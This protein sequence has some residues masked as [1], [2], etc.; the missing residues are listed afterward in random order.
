MHDFRHKYRH[1]K[2]KIKGYRGNEEQKI[3]DDS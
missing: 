3:Q 2:T 1:Y